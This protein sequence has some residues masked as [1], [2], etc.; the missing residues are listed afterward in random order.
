VQGDGTGGS[1][2]FAVVGAP[3]Y[4]AGIVVAVNRF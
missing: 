1:R 4:I 2:T 3:A